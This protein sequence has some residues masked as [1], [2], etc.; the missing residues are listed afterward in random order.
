MKGFP[1]RF[2]VE[3]RAGFERPFEGAQFV[4]PTPFETSVGNESVAFLI[5]VKLHIREGSLPSGHAVVIQNLVLEDADQ[6][7]F[8]RAATGELV[9]AFESGQEGFLHH[10]LSLR[11]VAQ[12]DERELEQI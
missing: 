7:A 3:A 2:A 4:N 9:P 12:A 11:R 10:V 6:P 5:R 1:E 8:L